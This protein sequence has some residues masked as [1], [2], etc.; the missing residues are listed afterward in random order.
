MGAIVSSQ[1]CGK[2]DV[3]NTLWRNRARSVAQWQEG[4]LS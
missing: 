4:V 3:K 2:N 1:L